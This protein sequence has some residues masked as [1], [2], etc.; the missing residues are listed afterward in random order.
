M[1]LARALTGP[2]SF[3]DISAY[4]P[5]SGCGSASVSHGAARPVLSPPPGAGAYG[6]AASYSPRSASTFRV[7][8]PEEGRVMDPHVPATSP[9]GPISTLL[10]F[11]DG[12]NP[13]SAASDA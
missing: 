1:A 2:V 11:Q 3:L 13:V 6:P 12:V 8:A 9:S 7:I 5:A 4:A 10:K